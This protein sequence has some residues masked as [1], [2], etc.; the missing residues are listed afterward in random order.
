MPLCKLVLGY[1]DALASLLASKIYGGA[2]AL[3]LMTCS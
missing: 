2:Q 1:A 3:F